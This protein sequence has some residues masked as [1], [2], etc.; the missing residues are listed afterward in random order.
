MK[1]YLVLAAALAAVAAFFLPP[2]PAHATDLAASKQ[3]VLVADGGAQLSA[4][5]DCGGQVVVQCDGAPMR[6]RTCA[7]SS[8][9]ATS[10]DLQLDVAPKAYD[11]LMGGAGTCHHYFSFLQ[12]GDAGTCVIVPVSPRTIP[13]YP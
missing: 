10:T 6:Y 1:R 8:C 4:S 7:T 9:T 13:I 5:I 11:V 2:L 12:T 3:T